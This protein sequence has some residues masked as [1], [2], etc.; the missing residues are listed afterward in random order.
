MIASSNHRLYTIACRGAAGG[1]TVIAS[2]PTT[3][4]PIHVAVPADQPFS[5]LIAT[6]KAS[7][8]VG[9]KP[10][11]VVSTT[12]A[13]NLTV[14]EFNAGDVART[15]FPTAA[16]PDSAVGALQ[17]VFV[18]G[19]PNTDFA[20]SGPA[21]EEQILATCTVAATPIAASSPTPKASTG[22]GAQSPA[23]AP[24][25]TADASTVAHNLKIVANKPGTA[26]ASV[27]FSLK[28]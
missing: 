24:G 27:V 13:C 8:R 22:A 14:L 11:I 15:I 9:G 5:L 12:Q 6:N 26:M 4:A 3:V 2:Q 17:S 18:A 25:K 28:P 10:A 20:L 7:Y 21:G 23:P 1:V 16:N 19:A